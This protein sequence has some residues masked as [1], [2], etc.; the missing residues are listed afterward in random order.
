MSKRSFYW[1]HLQSAIFGFLSLDISKRISW[2]NLTVKV[3]L[4]G[5]Y[6]DEENQPWL[7][8]WIWR[9][10]SQKTVFFF[11]PNFAWKDVMQSIFCVLFLSHTW[12]DSNDN[13]IK[14]AKRFYAF[15]SW[16]KDVVIL[17]DF[18]ARSLT[19]SDST[20][21]SEREFLKR[22]EGSLFSCTANHDLLSIFWTGDLGIPKREEQELEA[23]FHC[24]PSCTKSLL[25]EISSLE[26]L[27]FDNAHWGFWSRKWAKFARFCEKA[28]CPKN[29]P[30]CLNI[31]FKNLENLRNSP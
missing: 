28:I 14:L 25:S 26:F 27:F 1:N 6:F 5:Q 3:N 8:S 10:S 17:G 20:A 23:F 7:F 24:R 12:L 30:I 21:K 2:W 13:K 29:E 22:I 16:F 9:F 31:I 15:F 19:K 11:L 18:Y 4:F